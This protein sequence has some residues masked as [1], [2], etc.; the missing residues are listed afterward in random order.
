MFDLVHDTDGIVGYLWIGRDQSGDPSSWWI[1]D[2]VVEHEHR[3]R[4]YGR[5]AMQLAEAHAQAA[6]A[7]SLGLSVFG[8]NTVAL[9]LYESVGYAVTTVNMHKEL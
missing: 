5:Q 2:V 1:W 8:H 6:G 9:R 3:G 4:G 7:R